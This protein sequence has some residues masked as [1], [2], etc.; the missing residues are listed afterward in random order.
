MTDANTNINTIWNY[1]P[2]CQNIIQRLPY[3]NQCGGSYKLMFIVFAMILLYNVFMA[4]WWPDKQRVD[5]DVLNRKIFD[6]DYFMG[7]CCSMWPITHFI[8]FFILGLLFPN[9]DLPIITA[10]VLWEIAEES[11]AIFRRQQQTRHVVVAGT[12]DLQYRDSWWAGSLQDILFNILGFYCGK[13]LV[14]LFNINIC[15]RGLNC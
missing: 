1:V 10:G 7:N 11:I 14:K 4:M 12:G 9:C 13:L 8:F 3:G 6:F 5:V 15:V 2:P